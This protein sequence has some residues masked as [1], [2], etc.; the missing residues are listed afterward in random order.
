MQFFLQQKVNKQ[1]LSAENTDIQ[2]QH[3]VEEAVIQTILW[4]LCPQ[5]IPTDLAT[6]KFLFHRNLS[7]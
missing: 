7:S 4:L 2:D 5:T 3:F 1:H 6:Q